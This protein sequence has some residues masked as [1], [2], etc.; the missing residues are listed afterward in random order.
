VTAGS[1]DEIEEAREVPAP[2]G[3]PSE[4]SDAPHDKPPTTAGTAK[5][6]EKT[7]LGARLEA[8][9][10]FVISTYAT[11]DPRSLGSFRIALGTLLFFDVL[12]R[13]PD[14]DAHYTNA[15]WLT[16]HFALFRPM[17]SHLFSLYHAFGT[18][19]EVRVL[20][21][22]H[23]FVNFAL[24]IGWR[25]RLMHVLA[26]VLITGINSRNIML[27]N[28]GWV[29]LNLLTVWTM[30]LPLGKRFSVDALI[31]SFRER[32]EGSAQALNDRSVPAPTIAP[33]VSLAVTALI[34]QWVVIYAFNVV[35]KSGQPWR[36]GTAVY[37][38]FQQ[39]RMVTAFGA[40]IREVLPLSG[41][42]ALT[43]GTLAIEATIMAL[44]L[45]PF[46]ARYAR[47]LA[48][49]LCASLHLSI[50]AV[51]QLGPF[52][53]AMVIMF[54]VLI[55]ADLWERGAR[56]T[57]ER[58]APRLLLFDADDGL[59]IVFCRVIKRF[60]SLARV[61]FVPVHTKQGAP[62]RVDEAL[63]E[64]VDPAL[65]DR[66]LVVVESGRQYTG[67][68]A[69][70][71]LIGALPALWILL[72][73]VRVPGVSGLVGR[74]IERCA[75]RRRV[76]SEQLG[77]A[78][79]PLKPDAIALPSPARTSMEWLGNAGCQVGVLFL[80]IACGSQV[81]I[82]NRAVPEKLKPH[83]RPEWMTA[84]VVYPRLFQGWSMFA[85]GPPTEDGRIVVEGRTVDGRKLDPLTGQTPTYE[86]QP[87]GGFRMNQIWGDFHRRI[88]EPR[89][90]A[91]LQGVRDFLLNHHELTER[92]ADR[93][94]AF[95]IWYV[96][97]Q[98]PPPGRPKPPPSR[99]K[100]LTH[101]T[102]TP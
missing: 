21:A 66:T 73:W 12:R 28:G 5:S 27:E 20:F 41:I 37:Y 29:V 13:L 38:F 56:R 77:L 60:D 52:S 100:L 44:L 16:N 61:T 96:S 22:F 74:F 1:V 95:E 63:P 42:K 43:W 24:L 40:W 3:E 17:S 33:I 78:D 94:V 54:F 85:P 11:T 8:I 89:F 59:S 102:V 86:V 93:L 68:A 34:L 83:N 19:G 6:A 26:A 57:L 70:S 9:S 14:L 90:S 72:G 18:P 62:Y 79:V 65:V 23:L 87:K 46:R 67:I 88:G 53:W 15:G 10:R 31:R 76:L 25:T 99:R 55:P 91:Y 35:H 84:V 30:F 4:R 82:E 64:S 2:S 7:G 92:P 32:R 101:G 51:V 49:V 45:L 36:D 58:A 69:L 81:L 48:F 97:E 71:R 50:D 75:K 80:M 47:M 39:D 98:I